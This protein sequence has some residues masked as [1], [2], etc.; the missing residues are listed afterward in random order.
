ML[1]ET[2]PS[3]VPDAGRSRPARPAIGL[4]ALIPVLLFFI[5][6]MQMM[7]SFGAVGCDDD[8]DL[9]LISGGRRL[10]PWAA[11]FSIVIAIIIAVVLRIK[12]RSTH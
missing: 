3:P 6:W 10:Y 8:C 2:T 5:S 12:G 11:G 4:W 1:A 9:A 7:E